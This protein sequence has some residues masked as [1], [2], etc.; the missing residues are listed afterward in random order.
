MRTV[1]DPDFDATQGSGK[2]EAVAI[3]GA[4]ETGAR[5]S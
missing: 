3:L 1:K 2:F 5:S 4:K